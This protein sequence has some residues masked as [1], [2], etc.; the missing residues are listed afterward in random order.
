M[1]NSRTRAKARDY[2]LITLL[3]LVP[4]AASAQSLADAARKERDR[5][6][7]L[8]SVVVVNQG[9]T[10]VTSAGTGSTLAAPQVV[11]PPE[12]KDNNGHNE[13]Y[14]RERF[15]KARD[16]EK[17]A[18]ARAVLLDAKVKELNTAL[19]QRSDIYNREYRLGPE[20][21]QAQKDLEDAR[22]DAGE[23]KQ[24]LSDLEDEL[25]KAGGPAGWAR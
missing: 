18:E 5:Q 20:I 12:L 10:T 21:T 14:W 2:V 25:H 19:L 1:T 13:K 23:A 8:K 17:R 3:C 15:Q 4:A 11:K 6:K 24:R 7:Q 22:K 9:A 16:D